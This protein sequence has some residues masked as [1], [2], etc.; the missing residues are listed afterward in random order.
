MRISNIRYGFATNS[1]ST[2]SVILMDSRKAQDN[3]T[4]FEFG[5]DFWTAASKEAKARY[6]AQTVYIEAEKQL[7]HETA[8][9]IAKSL[10]GIDLAGENGERMGYLDHQSEILIPAGPGGKGIDLDYAKDLVK[11]LTSDGVVILGGNDNTEE[12]H[13]LYGAGKH[14]VFYTEGTPAA[15]RARKDG[16]HW[17]LF[18]RNSGTKFRISFEGDAAAKSLAPELVDL[19]ITDFCDIGCPFCYQNSTPKGVHAEKN[20]LEMLLSSLGQMRVFEVAIGGGEPTMHPHFAELLKGCRHRE[21]TPNF[22][23]KST[24]WMDGP[25]AAAIIERCGGFAYSIGATHEAL[26]V[27]KRVAKLGDAALAKL[28]FQYVMGST[29]LEDFASILNL[30]GTLHVPL[31]LLGYKQVGR[32]PAFKVHDYSLWGEIVAKERP[33][34]RLSIDTA[35]AATSGQVLADLK[36]PSWLYDVQEGKHS[37]YIDAVTKRIAPSSF[38]AQEQYVSIANLEYGSLENAIRNSFAGW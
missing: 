19:K 15:W 12:T 10:T 31:T 21:I 33:R 11:F 2:H 8:L 6:A 36:V 13:P 4:D 26:A 5:W 24:R 34:P 35:L 23:T 30:A 3:G 28:H 29:E 22:T 1:S 7:G 18:N 17:T 9:L 38:C 14:V 37:M 32:G 25:D 20:Y 27:F 16:K